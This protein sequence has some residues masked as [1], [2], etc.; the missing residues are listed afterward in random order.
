[1]GTFCKYLDINNDL[2]NG[3]C[4]GEK[5]AGSMCTMFCS[6]RQANGDRCLL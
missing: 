1:M 3:W 4:C 2:V 5:A 6:A